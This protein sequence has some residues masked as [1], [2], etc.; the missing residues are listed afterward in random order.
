MD[1]Y[2]LLER[3]Q[4]Q[5][6]KASTDAKAEA[7]VVLALEQGLAFKDFMA[8]CDSFFYREYS[9]DVL[10]TEIKEDA[11]RQTFLQVHLTRCGI[12]DGLP[13]GLFFQPQSSAKV[14]GATQMA[15][16]Y[17]LNKKKESSV[18]NFFLPFENDFFW[19]RVQ[20]EIEETKLLQGLESGILTD[21]FIKFWGLPG[22]IPKNF[23]TPLILLLPYANKIAGHLTLTEQCLQLLLQETVQIKKVAA[24]VTDVPSFFSNE[25][26]QQLLS[27]DA[28]CGKQFDEDY[29]VL[30]FL[31]GPLKNSA[32]H[33]YLEGGK[34]F[35]LLETFYSFFVPVG[36][37]VLTNIEVVPQRKSMQ[38]GPDSETI[39]G[40][41]T[42][43]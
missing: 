23:I 30:Q 35:A 18:R 2:D 7:Q 29:P 33:D 36:I 26:G 28:V 10:F 34:R 15:E 25:L 21:Y 19:Q 27:I 8:C 24:P 14:F 37:D 22:S 3:L 32:I 1:N 41:S 6:S 43:L 40:Y 11:S 39:L 17:K 31:I 12:S 13:E 4:H 20:L 9:K 5:M 38:L 16:E 42:V